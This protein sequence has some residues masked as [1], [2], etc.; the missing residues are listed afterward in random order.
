[1]TDVFP[2]WENI[3]SHGLKPVAKVSR[4]FFLVRKFARFANFV[5]KHNHLINMCLHKPVIGKWSGVRAL[6]KSK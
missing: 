5:T 1:M 3:N 4:Y 2:G 6:S